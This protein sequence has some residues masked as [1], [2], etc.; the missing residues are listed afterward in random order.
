MK[1][2]NSLNKTLKVLLASLASV[3]LFLVLAASVFAWLARSLDPEVEALIAKFQQ[4]SNSQAYQRLANMDS[5]ELPDWLCSL[6]QEWQG[7]SCLTAWQQAEPAEIRALV[8]GKQQ[9]L[10]QMHDFLVLNDW[11]MPALAVD[12][13]SPNWPALIGHPNTGRVC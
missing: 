8:L 1:M 10:V 13:P 2:N 5:L 4:P 11:Q 3:V 12:E 9:A 6:W 7:Q